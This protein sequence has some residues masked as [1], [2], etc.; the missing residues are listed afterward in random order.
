M[1]D[2]GEDRRG[3]HPLALGQLGLTHLARLQ[4]VKP[5]G[6]MSKLMPHH[7]QQHLVGVLKARQLAIFLDPVGAAD[8]APRLER[9]DNPGEQSELSLERW[10]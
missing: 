7:A 2:Q 8:K 4:I 3:C 1:L 10:A 6:V 5:C 9:L